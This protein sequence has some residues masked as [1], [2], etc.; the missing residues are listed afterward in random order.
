MGASLK[1]ESMAKRK[2]KLST[3]DDVVWLKDLEYPFLVET[4]LIYVN[5]LLFLIYAWDVR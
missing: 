1:I 5:F 3:C 4:K 2:E